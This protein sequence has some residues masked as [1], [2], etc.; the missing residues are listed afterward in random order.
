[1]WC[2]AGIAMGQLSVKDLT[3][4]YYL[5]RKDIEAIFEK[6]RELKDKLRRGE[7]YE[8]LRG[9]S[10]AMIFEKP[11]LRTRVSFEVAMTQLGGHAIYLKYPVKAPEEVRGFLSDVHMAEPLKDIARVLSRYVDVIVARTYAQETVDKLARYADVPVINALTNDLHPCQTLADLYTV[12]EKK[13]RLEGLKLAYIGDGGCNTAH[14]TMIGCAKMGMDITI[15]CPSSPDGRYEP[16]ELYLKWAK[17]ATEESGSKIEIVHDPVRAV[18]GADVIY[19]D[20]WVSMGMEAEMEE[21]LRVFPPFQVNAELLKHAKEDVIVL[22]CLPAYRGKEITEEVIEGPHSV[23]FDEAENRLHTQ[24]ALLVL[25]L[26][27]G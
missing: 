16:R 10:M 8:P 12:L 25:L 11:S 15:G 22:H 23:V 6:T 1:M 3:S 2:L 17:E 18:E 4:L 5:T 20:T 27:E 7:S 19:T 9:R 24:K 26:T 21:R 14:S 13:G